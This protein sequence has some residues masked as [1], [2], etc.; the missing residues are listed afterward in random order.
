MTDEAYLE[1]VLR[2][3]DA[4]RDSAPP[5]VSRLLRSMAKP[6]TFM[7]DRLI[8]AE[9]IEAVLRGA[10]WAASAS[11][12][13]AAID[14]DFTDLRACDDAASE[15]WRWAMGYAVTG[16]GAMGAFGAMGLAVDVPATITL[17]LRTTRLHG[18]CY[19][20]G[21]DSEAERIFILD[22][23]QL[24][25]ANSL[26]EKQASLARL[27]ED[28]T[29]LPAESFG[30]IVNLTGQAAGAQAAARRVAQV[31]GTNLSARKVAQMAPFVG[32]AIGASVNASFQNDVAAAARHAYRERW[33]QVNEGI[34]R[35]EITDQR[36]ETA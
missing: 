25:G 10:D 2:E 31:L 20:F 17:A 13:Q 21:G 22:T 16:G 4:Y 26:A 23:L 15:I 11:I 35:G 34:V 33:L 32:A 12:R 5:P 29:T 30:R 3:Q 27:A 9:A 19:G 18:L 24:A 8:P 7:A 28:R 1:Q 14:H 36:G 6:L